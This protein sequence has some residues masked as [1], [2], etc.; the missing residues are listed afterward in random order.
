MSGHPDNNRRESVGQVQRWLVVRTKPL[1]ERTAV[2]HLVQRE[3]SPYCPMFLQPPWHP[4]APRGPVPLFPGYV[5]VRCVPDR[6][7]NAVRYCPG[8]L[9]PISFGGRVAEID[10]GVIRALRLREGARGYAVPAEQEEGI[11]DGSNVRVMSGPLEGLEGV[12]RGYLRGRQRARI[13]VEF[14]RSRRQVEVDTSALAVMR[15]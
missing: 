14:L 10:D 4:R 5:F 2:R 6:Q 1:Q 15:A 3:V 8:V 7:L 9:G 13:L 11:A 12:F